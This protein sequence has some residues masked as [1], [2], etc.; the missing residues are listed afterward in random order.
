MYA[1]EWPYIPVKMLE[2]A[3]HL[4]QD[5]ENVGLFEL[6]DL[7]HGSQAAGKAALHDDEAS[8]P[9]VHFPFV[10]LEQRHQILSVR[11]ILTRWTH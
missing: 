3:G 1:C 8:G 4:L 11:L 5:V 2:A 6:D 7:L 9:A 10:V